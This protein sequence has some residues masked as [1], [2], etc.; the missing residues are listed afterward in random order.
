[1]LG[2]NHGCDE[3][4]HLYAQG[5]SCVTITKCDNVKIETSYGTLLTKDMEKHS[6]I[7]T[8]I[9]VGSKRIE[10]D[11]LRVSNVHRFSFQFE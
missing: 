10:F 4:F 1:M 11:S 2:S 6:K 9:L 3:V 7:P 8:E 5:P